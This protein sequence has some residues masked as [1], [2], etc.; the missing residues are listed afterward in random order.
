MSHV[1]NPFKQISNLIRSS[2]IYWIRRVSCFKFIDTCYLIFMNKNHLK[3]LAK[4]IFVI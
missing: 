3:K 4:G 2:L 1:N